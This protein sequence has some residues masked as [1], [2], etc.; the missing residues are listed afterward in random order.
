MLSHTELKKGIRFIIDK[1]PYEVLESSL[2]FKGRGSSVVQTKIKNLIN[3]KVISE[4]FHHGDSFEET[5]IEKIQAKFLYS[6][7]DRFFFSK[8]DN[9]SFRFDLSKEALGESSRFLKQNQAVETI[10]FEE[11]IINILLPV[12]VQLK[13]AEAPPGTK[14]DRA[15]GGTK[16]IVLETGVSINT[17]LF[18][19]EG[20]IVE[21]NTEKGEYVRRVE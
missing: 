19:E 16:V 21:I 17:P 4:T 14:G 1:E 5:E 8:E 15:Q 9:P 3:G 13:V 7:K 6:H 18:I 12:K 2:V 11:R 10:Q 20:D